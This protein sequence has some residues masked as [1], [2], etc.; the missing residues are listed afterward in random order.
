MAEVSLY[1]FRFLRCIK[2]YLSPYSVTGTADLHK[3]AITHVS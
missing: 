1:I 2:S 3:E